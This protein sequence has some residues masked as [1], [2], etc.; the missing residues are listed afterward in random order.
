MSTGCPHVGAGPSTMLRS[1]CRARLLN[2]VCPPTLLDLLVLLS[3]AFRASSFYDIFDVRGSSMMMS[4]FLLLSAIS[5]RTKTFSH[6]TSIVLIGNG[7][8]STCIS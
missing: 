8:V 6:A 5:G 1:G 3:R 7:C 2:C 4:L